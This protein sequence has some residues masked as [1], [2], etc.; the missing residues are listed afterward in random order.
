MALV[1][2]FL[3][4]QCLLGLAKKMADIT[5]PGPYIGLSVPLV[6]IPGIWLQG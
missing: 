3:H 2:V 4:D 5:N 6:G 1:E